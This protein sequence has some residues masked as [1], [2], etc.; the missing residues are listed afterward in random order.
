MSGLIQVVV[1]GLMIGGV[2]ALLAVGLTM[3]FGVMKIINFAQCEYLMMGMYVTYCLYNLFHLDADSNPYLFIIPVATFMFIFGVVIYQVFIRPIVGRDMVSFI[4]LTMGLSYVL[5]NGAQILWTANPKSIDTAIRSQSIYIGSID[6]S[7]P[8][9]KL[10]AFVLAVA[11]VLLVSAFLKK[12]DMGR[13]M[14]A[15]S[16]N[17]QIAALLGIN[18]K[19]SYL[20]AFGLGSLFAGVA[21][22]LLSPIYTV[23]PRIGTLFS[24]T[25]FAV[26]VLGGLG[27]V[28]GALFGGLLIGIVENMVGTFIALDLAPVGVFVLFIIVMLLKPNGLFG[29]GGRKA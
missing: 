28:T 24:T 13:A 26:V 10:V 4:L 22:V 3:I 2:Y 23:Y 19:K 16:E 25:I 5:Q 8:L 17:D 1:N 9:A 21:G 11:F 7:I 20:L 12:T 18:T 29:T 14:R 15:T 6:L 27:S